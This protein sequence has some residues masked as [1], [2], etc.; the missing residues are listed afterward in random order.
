MSSSDDLVRQAKAGYKQVPQV[1]QRRTAVVTCIDT[2]LDPLRILKADPGDLHVLRNAGGVITED[3]IRSLVVSTNRLQVNTVMLIMHTDCGMLNID[4]AGVE[5]VLGP[6]PFDLGGFSDLEG[7]LQ[8]GAA[9]IRANP[10]LDLSGGVTAHV[11]DV[12]NG[13]LRLHKG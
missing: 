10:L 11:Y 12:T 1:P 8:R 5:A 13:S 2:R 6:L 9:R 7:E 3:V 4:Q